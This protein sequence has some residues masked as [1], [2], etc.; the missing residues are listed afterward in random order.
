MGLRV[1]WEIFVSVRTFSERITSGETCHKGEQ[2]QPRGQRLRGNMEE[3][4]GQYIQD[5]VFLNES[6]YSCCH[7]SGTWDSSFISHSAWPHIR[8]CPGSL[9][10]I[11]LTLGLI[12]PVPGISAFWTKQ[13]LASLDLHSAD[14]HHKVVRP[15]IMWSSLLNPLLQLHIGSFGSIL[16]RNL[17]QMFNS[18]S[19]HYN[20]SQ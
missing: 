14:D 6:I 13:L 17:T 8:D 4:A 11:R 18:L 3:K 20:Y 5:P 10:P 9:Q 16:W 12:T 19:S 2:H 15:L 1:T 7:H